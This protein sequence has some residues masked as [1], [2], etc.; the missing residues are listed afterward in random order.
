MRERE[1]EREGEQGCHQNYCSNKATR[2]ETI[3]ILKKSTLYC[4]ILE[5]DVSVRSPSREPN[6]HF[7]I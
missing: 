1:R 5:F 3:Q 2:L 4:Q 7:N 6:G